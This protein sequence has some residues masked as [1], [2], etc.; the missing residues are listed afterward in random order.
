MIKAD[1][2]LSDYPRPGGFPVDAVEG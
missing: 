1:I 2:V